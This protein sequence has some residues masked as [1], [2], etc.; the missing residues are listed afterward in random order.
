V[1]GNELMT[2]YLNVGVAN[3][4]SVVTIASFGDEGYR[5]NYAAADTYTHAFAA[6]PLRA[7]P[8]GRVIALGDDVL[9]LPIYIVDRTGHI[10]GVYRR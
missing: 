2:G 1:F 5:V 10:T 6:P 8:A 4:L 9:R 3:P 7:A